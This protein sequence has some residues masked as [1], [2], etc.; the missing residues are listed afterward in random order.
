MAAR[1]AVSEELPRGW[2]VSPPRA[3]A[4]EAVRHGQ[5]VQRQPAAAFGQGVHL[6]AW[7]D[8]SRQIDRPTAD[9]YCAR[10]EAQTGRL[11]DPKGIAVCS[12]V[13]LQEWPQVAF[14]GTNF[15]VVW[16]DFRSGKHYDVYAARVSPEGRVL[17]KDGFAVAAGPYNQ[18]RPDVAFAGGKS[19]IVW[20]DAR[21]YPVYGIFAARVTAAG[22]VLDPQ[23]LALDVEDET[24]IAEV[25]PPGP[26]WMGER[27]YWWDKL[28][29]RYLPAISSNGRQCMVAY[30]RDYP[31]A[32]GARPQPTA[33]LVDAERG[34]VVAGPA[35]LAGG[36]HDT[37]AVCSTPEGWAMVLMDHAHGWGLAPRLAAVRLDANLQTTDAFAKPHSKEPNRLPVEELSKTLMPENTGTLNPGKGAVAFWRPAAAFDG[38]HMVVATDFGW[39]ARNRPN[40]ITY[41]IATNRLAPHGKAFLEPKSLVLASTHRAE[42]SVANPA[43]IAGSGGETLLF[44][45]HDTAIDRQVIEVRILRSN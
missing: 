29:S 26:A 20:M 3:V 35:K 31:F 17:D 42:Q 28:A 13:D 38:R 40:D 37:L 44:Y 32:G 8:G 34:E 12:A 25:R 22:E 30:A 43:L 16:Q 23:G 45:E 19:L 10:I 36:A 24:S 7:C 6:V 11:L 1:W 14:D 4:P 33:V 9:I 18:G 2:S 15:L 41:V 5:L 27:D 39:R 21:R